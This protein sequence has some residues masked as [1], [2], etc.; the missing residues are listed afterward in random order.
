MTGPF[1]PIEQLAEHFSVSQSTIRAWVRRGYIPKNTY[2]KVGNVYRF[3]KDDVAE[4]LVERR[5]GIPHTSEDTPQSVEV[6]AESVNSTAE[7]S[8]LKAV[9][10]LDNDI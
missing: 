3:S 5:I 6:D 7:V 2:I 1:I 4:A 8:Y 10:D 9:D